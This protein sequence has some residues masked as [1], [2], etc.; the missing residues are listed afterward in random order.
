MWCRSLIL[1]FLAACPLLAADPILITIDTENLSLVW[2]DSHDRSIVREVQGLTEDYSILAVLTA[3]SD[4]GAVVWSEDTVTSD[5]YI[6]SYSGTG[7]LLWSWLVYGSYEMPIGSYHAPGDLVCVTFTDPWST[8]IPLPDGK[9][10]CTMAILNATTGV[11]VWYASILDAD[12]FEGYI[13]GHLYHDGSLIL[14]NDYAPIG[15]INDVALSGPASYCCI[16]PDLTGTMGT[17]WTETWKVLD[18][19]SEESEFGIQHIWRNGNH[20]VM[21]YEGDVNYHY[22]LRWIDPATGATV[23]DIDFYNRTVGNWYDWGALLS[24]GRFATV[25]PTVED[26]KNM[27]IIIV[28]PVTEASTNLLNWGYDYTKPEGFLIDANDRLFVTGND[29]ELELLMG[30]TVDAT[31]FELD[32]D[33]EYPFA[34]EWLAIPGDDAYQLEGY[35]MVCEVPYASPDPEPEAAARRPRRPVF[36]QEYD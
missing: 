25:R 27:Q 32:P 11:V 2:I 34:V 29:F 26:K 36:V 33:D 9:T 15:K 1:V 3:T 31:L 18:P 30:G 10:E 13:V 7:T 21:R 24:D 19:L 14:I 8:P 23:K 4:D 20:V 16:Q 6:Q 17:A 22:H 28:D 35:T 12:D 5:N